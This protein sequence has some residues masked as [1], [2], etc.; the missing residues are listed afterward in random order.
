[1]N[2]V[3]IRFTAGFGDE[4]DNVP[5]RI[6]TA[7]KLLVGHLYENREITDI[8]EHFEIPFAIKSLLGL[9]RIVPV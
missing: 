3:N 4:A 9:D 2:G 7:I 6:R 5:K 1:M 8:R